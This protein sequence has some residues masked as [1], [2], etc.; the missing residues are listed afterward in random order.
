MSL[1]VLSILTLSAFLTANISAVAG[2][3]G[4]V[5]L[6]SAMTFILPIKLIVPVHGVV[7]LISNSSRVFMLRKS[8]NRKIFLWFS[9]GLPIGTII[10]IRLITSL[11]DEKYLYLLIALIIFYSLFKPK[12]LP[13]LKIPTAMFSILGILVGVLGP[14]I[15]ATGPLVAPFMLR[16]DLTKEEIIST[17]ASIQMLGHFIKI[18]TFIF[19]GFDYFQY[20]TLTLSMSVA[21]V[22][23]TYT[24]VRILKHITQKN[25]NLIFKTALF[26]AAIRL[27]Y[28]FFT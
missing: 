2:M 19:L 9:L 1:T 21:V 17:K 16:D 4:G 6:L 15:G 5:L 27:L 11:S 25:F 22:L 24:G 18:P 12:V 7:Q 8:V 26:F 14:L 10:S 20:S 3:A 23:G 28:K 13:S